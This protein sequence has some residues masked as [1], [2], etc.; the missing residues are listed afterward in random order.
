MNDDTPSFDAAGTGN[1][2]SADGPPSAA[3]G[4]S[5]AR[6]AQPPAPAAMRP[7]AMR[8]PA[9]WLYP[10][11]IDRWLVALVAAVTLGSVLV[12]FSLG[13]TAGQASARPGRHVVAPE[14]RIGREWPAEPRWAVPGDPD[15]W[16]VPDPGDG[17]PRGGH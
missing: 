13:F 17:C 8:P 3:A 15:V 6:P 16:V 2:P 4:A 14:V 11:G 1:L 12:G 10:G 5:P 9:P 7:P